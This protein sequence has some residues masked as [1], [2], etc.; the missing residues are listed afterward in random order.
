VIYLILSEHWA[1]E[2]N[3]PQYIAYSSGP[4]GKIPRQLIAASDFVFMFREDGSTYFYKNR[5]FER[6][7]FTSEERLLIK[8]KSVLI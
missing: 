7:D 6:T 3:V 8:L 4:M 2:S 1:K 5:H